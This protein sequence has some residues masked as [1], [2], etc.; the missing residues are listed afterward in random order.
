MT[1]STTTNKVVYIGNGIATTFAIPFPFLER[2][3]LKVRQL[4]NNVQTER[5]DWTVS[6]GNMVFATAPADDAQIVI[7]REVPLTQETD[8]RENEVLPAE[9]LE[10]NFDKLTMQI[11][12]LKEQAERAVTVDLFSA[13][14]PSVLVDKIEK[15]Y[16]IKDEI[17]V[18]AQNISSL[19]TV[20]DDISSIHTAATHISAITDAINQATQASSSANKARIWAEGTD[21]EIVSVN[22]IHS[23]KRW[24]EIMDTTEF[25]KTY[26]ASRVLSVPQNIKI[27][28]TAGVVKL[29][30]GSVVYDGNGNNMRLQQDLSLNGGFQG[31]GLLV[32]SKTG[33]LWEMDLTHVFSQTTEPAAPYLWYNPNTKITRFNDN[34]GTVGEVYLPCAQVVYLGSSYVQID[35]VFNGIGCIASTVFVLPHIKGQALQSISSDGT[36]SNT[37]WETSGVQT[38]AVNNTLHLVV[39]ANGMLNTK[40]TFNVFSDIGFTDLG[41][42]VV[43][44]G[45]IVSMPSRSIDTINTYP[46]SELAKMGMPG[47]KRLIVVT[48]ASFATYIAPANRFFTISGTVEVNSFAFVDIENLST[49][50]K[51]SDHSYTLGSTISAYIPA[52][53]G[54]SVQIAYGQTTPVVS[55]IYAEG[56]E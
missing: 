51:D 46:T 48:G 25:N 47:S 10:R 55:F 53:A 9:T 27:S 33:H 26:T 56:E 11:Q 2:E 17:V 12:Q 7:M 35:R 41:I 1:V 8:Y 43:S 37:I 40:S 54:E 5:T 13:S 14:D 36:C 6:G 16:R 22:G 52:K 30:A 24:A 50:I 3:H 29:T 31:K 45:S 28:L 21:E 39:D 38:V 32:V 49:F 44:G 19:T 4:L 18:A 15:L 23:A 20:S 34:L 42:V